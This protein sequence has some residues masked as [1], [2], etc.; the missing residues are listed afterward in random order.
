[1]DYIFRKPIIC[2]GFRKRINSK[3]AI[4]SADENYRWTNWFNTMD[5]TSNDGDIEAIGLARKRMY[6][7]CR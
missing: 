3:M 1:M 7:I 2:L 6:P 5:P 4:M